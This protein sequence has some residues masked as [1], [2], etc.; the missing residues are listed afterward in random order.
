MPTRI[1]ARP[2]NETRTV[3][4]GHRCTRGAGAIRCRSYASTRCSA[5]APPAAPLLRGPRVRPRGLLRRG[6]AGA[7]AR[8]WAARPR[9]LGL[10]GAPERG[11]LQALLEGRDPRAASRCRGL[12]AGRRNAGFDLTFTAPKSVSVLLAVGDERGPPRGPGRPRGRRRRRAWTTWSATSSRPAAAPAARRIVA[13]HGFVG[14]RYTHEMSRSGDPHLHTHVV[15]AN[16]VRGPDGRYSAPDMRPIFA[17]AKTAGILAEAVLRHALTQAP[18]RGVGAGPANGH[19]RDRRRP[20]RSCGPLLRPPPGDRRAG[21][22][23]AACTSLPAVGAAQ[24][25]TRDRKPVIDRDTAPGRLAGPGGRAGLRPRR[26]RPRPRSR[27]RATRRSPPAALGR[28]RGPPGRPRGPDPAGL[29]LHPP[30]GAARLRRGPRPRRA[31]RA[32]GGAGRRLPGPAGRAPG[33]RRSR[34]AGGAPSTPPRSCW[35]PRGACSPWPGSATS[36]CPL[37]RRVG[38]RGPFAPIRTWAPTS[39]RR[40]ATWPPATGAC[41]CWRPTPGGARPPPWA[42]WPTPTPAPGDPV[43]GTAWQGEAAQTLHR[44]AGVPAETAARL[45][46]RLARDPEALPTDARA[47]RGRGGHHAHPGPGRAARARGRP[48]RAPDPGG[49]PGPAPGH[50]RRRRLRRPGRSPGRG[51]PQRESPPAGSRAARGGRRAGR[52]APARGPGPA[53]APTAACAPSP[54]RRTPAPS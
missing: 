14:A 21:G 50:R 27:G 39:G 31:A 35:A 48:P 9:H 53:R 28:P 25:E 15:V 8:S 24:R 51:Q 19:G 26:A 4:A 40:C 13:A 34:S 22:R 30:R 33:A 16:A 1:A 10:E 12:R 46:R 43:R 54:P 7:G 29:H 18:R 38:G 36:G 3:R 44:E 37:A 6:R 32:P 20:V 49:R 52:G 11:E 42:R 17:A 5:S 47:H 23:S 2:D 41:A 45:L